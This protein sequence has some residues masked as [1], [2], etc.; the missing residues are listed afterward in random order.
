MQ[1]KDFIKTKE[2][3]GKHTSQEITKFIK[4]LDN[5]TQEEITAWLK[6]VK[7]NGLD[8]KETTALCAA[9]TNTGTVLSWKDLEPT[10]DKHS[11]GGIGDKVSLLFAPLMAAYGINVP[12]LSGRSLGITG[13]TLDK[14]ESI[15]GFQVNL[16]ANQMKEQVKKIG[17][18]IASASKD[19]APA[20]KKLYVI[21]DVTNTIDSIPLIASSIMA[22]KFAGGSENIIFDV[23]FGS[24]AFMKTLEKAKVLASELVSIGRSENKKVKAVISNMNEPLGLAIGNTLEIKE[25]LDVLSGKNITDLIEIVVTLAYEAVTLIEPKTNS[26]LEKKLTELLLNG[27][28]L[29]KFEQM[30][31]AQGGILKDLYKEDKKAKHIEVIKSNTDGFIQNINAQVIGEVVHSLGAGRKQVSD[32]IDHSVGIILNKKNG[33]KVYKDESLLEIHAKNKTEA[34][35]AKNKA[36]SAITI[37]QN[38]PSKLKLI[39]E[40]IK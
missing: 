9:M 24:G 40:I 25:V 37:G 33:D 8:S 31:A 23:K 4:E 16:S 2:K 14:L 29:K 7:T 10:I 28:S 35:Q 12:K 27:S 11:T 17:L 21:R 15:P 18:A 39:E 36:T 26:S 13:G 3:S 34:E 30:I 22:K 32:I 19:L 1:I 20:E 5:I 38:K 6:A